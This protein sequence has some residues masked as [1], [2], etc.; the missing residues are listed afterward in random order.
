MDQ[1]D[2]AD[3]LSLFINNPNGGIVSLHYR[4]Q[5]I[6]IIIVST[7]TLFICWGQGLIRVTRL[8]NGEFSIER[9]NIQAPMN[10][11]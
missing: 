11:I 7:S 4:N 10:G 6:Q 8:A 5:F 1:I 2:D 3:D 9:I